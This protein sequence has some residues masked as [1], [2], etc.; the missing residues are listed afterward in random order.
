MSLQ[1]LSL[2]A[3]GG[4]GNNAVGRER[5]AAE[6]R[7]L[8]LRRRLLPRPARAVRGAVPPCRAAGMLMAFQDSSN[9]L[10]VPAQAWMRR[11]AAVGASAESAAWRGINAAQEWHSPLPPISWLLNGDFRHTW[12]GRWCCAARRAAPLRPPAAPPPPLAPPPQPPRLPLLPRPS[13]LARGCGTAGR[14]CAA[15]RVPPWSRS[16]VCIRRAR[17]AAPAGISGRKTAR[18]YGRLHTAIM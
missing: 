13:A 6:G 11:C 1:C 7:L 10:G 2:A 3:P 9:R 18:M 14:L 8:R 5:Q 15:R 4:G 17:T 16:T 12:R